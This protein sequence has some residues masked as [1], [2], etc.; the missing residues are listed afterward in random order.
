MIG[1]PASLKVLWLGRWP[2]A[3]ELSGVRP[4]SISSPFGGQTV[5]FQEDEPGQGQV[6]E[7]GEFCSGKRPIQFMVVHLHTWPLLEPSR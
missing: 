4:D 7:S 3:A 6:R 1:L 2:I 5:L